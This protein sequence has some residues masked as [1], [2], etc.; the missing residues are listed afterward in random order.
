MNLSGVKSANQI[1]Y[2][3]YYILTY[4]KGRASSRSVNVSAMRS[5]TSVT[6]WRPKKDAFL[7][8]V[9]RFEDCWEL[10]TCKIF[11]TFSFVTVA[12]DVPQCGFY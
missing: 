4:L 2:V 9:R 1:Q 12:V 11:V 10:V 3:T 5:F 6:Q 7:H 8:R